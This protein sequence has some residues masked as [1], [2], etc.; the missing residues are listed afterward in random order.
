MKYLYGAAVQGIQNF[1]FQTNK[2]SEITGAS[3]LVSKICTEYFSEVVTGDPQIVV[4]AAGN[5]KC[6]FHD[7]QSCEEIVRIFPK[8]IL[9]K[10]PG[11]TISQAVVEL[12]SADATTDD[13]MELESRLRTQRNKADRPT[14]IG[15]MSIERSR[16]TGLP[17]IAGTR[18]DEATSSKK[19]ILKE[20]AHNLCKIAFGDDMTS[21]RITYDTDEMIGENNWIAVIHADGNGLGQV[22]QKIAKQ[23][24]AALAEFSRKLDDANK[25]SAQSAFREIN[26]KYDL[27]STKIPIRPIVLSGDDFTMICRGD[28][29]LDYAKSFIKHF[30]E[31]TGKNGD[32][33]TACAGIAYVKS[34]FPFYYGYEMAESLCSAAKADAKSLADEQSKAPSCIMFHKIEDSFT[35][36]YN[37]IKER[38]LTTR[39]KDKLSFAFGPYYINK[40]N[41]RWTVDELQEWVEK[42]SYDDKDCNA[43][44]SHIRQWLSIRFNDAGQAE[45]KLNR[46]IKT[47]ESKKDIIDKLTTPQGDKVPAYDVLSQHSV[48]YLRTANK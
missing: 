43:V 32:M 4:Q 44:K 47:L 9:E 26:E 36:S 23:G 28:F 39:T 41:D 5:V 19:S 15:L 29:A 7:R 25:K 22:V 42:L 37:E 31:E 33:L 2:L 18:E 11:V 3:E 27:G 13:F 35:D 1:I 45:L 16:Q 10:V 21:S 17:L 38:V 6:I 46:I 30:E 14:T 34:S 48:K 12:S 8:K 20:T 24:T 40:M